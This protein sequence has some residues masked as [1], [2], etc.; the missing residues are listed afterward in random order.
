MPAVPFSEEPVAD[1]WEVCA[2]MAERFRVL[3]A[4]V[5]RRGYSAG[6]SR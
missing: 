5:L 4:E 2:W 1:L 6:A 3:V